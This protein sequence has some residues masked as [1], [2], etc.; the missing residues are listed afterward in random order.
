MGLGSNSGTSK[1]FLSVGFGKLRQ[2][3]LAN[4]EKVNSNTP[5][6]VKRQT[7]QGADTWAI[8]YD[9]IEGTIDTMFYKVDAEYGNSFEVV[10]NDGQDNY[11]ISFGDDSRFW[12]DLAKKL[13]NIQLLFPVKLNPFD[14]IDKQKNKRHVGLSVEQNGVKILSFYDKKNTDGTFTSLYDFPKPD[15]DINWND[16]DEVKVYSIKVKKFLKKEVETRIIPKF[17]H[18]DESVIN[19]FETTDDSLAVGDFDLPF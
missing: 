15:I 13:P 14:F 6:A 12:F 18:S 10:I 2:K 7:Q 17:S 1:I 8:E 9:W 4:K 3:S 5:G 16:K 19:K 11:Q